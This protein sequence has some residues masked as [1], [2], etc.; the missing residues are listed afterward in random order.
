MKQLKI[1]TIIPIYNAEK[2]LRRCLD[3]VISQSYAN[4]EIILV[5]DGST[6]NSGVICDEY[7]QNDTRIKVLHKQNSGVSEARNSA[8]DLVEGDYIH[9]VDAD[10]WI[11]KDTYKK[12]VQLIDL[13]N[14]NYDIIK[15]Y[16]YN[17]N[18]D[19]INKIPFKGC[20]SDKELEDI[21]LSYVGS[22]NFGG[23]FIMGVPWLYLINNQLIQD[24]H[25][26]FN[27]DLSRC[28]DRLFI[29]TTLLQAKNL[30]I[31]DDVFYHYETSAGSLSNKY[32]SFR[33]EQEKLYL[34][35]LQREYSKC[36][37][38]HF[39]DNANSRIV[40]EYYLRALI[41]VDNE[42]FSQNTN[43]FKQHYSNIKKI[44]NDPALVSKSENIKTEKL[45][46]K[47]KISLFLIKRRY[48]F[49]LSTF[50]MLLLLKNKINT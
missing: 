27:K 9:F 40:N 44:L 21:I 3:S 2:Y 16:G 46:L 19:I 30:L 25:I 28:E 36:K 23:L 35:E 15:F 7:K 12:L 41:S 10:D 22:L 4:I 6:D 5:N 34:T 45:D 42:F 26:R 29:I 49:L 33:W 32:D 31:I 39:V 47:R 43:S 8:L 18:N 14:T 48:S 17:S 13:D 1:S 20:Y 24:H 11:E 50:N 38:S 37:S